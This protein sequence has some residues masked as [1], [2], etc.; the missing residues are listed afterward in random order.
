MN[1]LA[2]DK[3]YA[4]QDFFPAPL[5]DKIKAAIKQ[6]NLGPEGP[7]KYHPVAGR[8]IEAISFEPEVEEEILEIARKVFNE[9]DLKRAGF[10]TGRYQMQNGIKPQLWKHYDQSACQYSLDV[11][12][13]K[14][15][16]WELVVEEQ[17]FLEQPNSC[18]VF[19]GNDQMHWRTEYPSTDEND[20]V[21]LLFMQF[22]KP[23]HWYF[24][25]PQGFDKY[26]HI[27]DFRFRERTGYWAQPDYSD[28]RPICSCCDYRPV[29]GF[30][31]RYQAGERY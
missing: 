29:L 7:H 13:E 28:G 30:E 20:Y 9:P 17:V 21:H 6:L 2:E 4:L 3:A 26:G 23:D 18:V 14:T 22:A 5:F 15:I 25:D 27:A 11:C 31:D 19:H 10:H 8:W 1:N 12:I 16:D 24:T